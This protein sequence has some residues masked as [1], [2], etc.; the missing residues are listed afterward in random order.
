MGSLF[1]QKIAFSGSL[2][3]LDFLSAYGTFMALFW[4]L[5]KASFYAVS[6]SF[7]ALI[8]KC[9]IWKLQSYFYDLKNAKYVEKSRPYGAENHGNGYELYGTTCQE[10]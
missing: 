4:Q 1:W 10:A 6:G 3:Q 9:N 2:W 5:F 8:I 7:T